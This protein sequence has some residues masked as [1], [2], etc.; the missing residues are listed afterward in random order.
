MRLC[1]HVTNCVCLYV[2]VHVSICITVRVWRVDKRC[3]KCASNLLDRFLHVLQQAAP[4]GH[5]LLFRYGASEMVRAE[6][7]MVHY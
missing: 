6:K 5:L 2:T 7:T 1:V 3:T 4:Y